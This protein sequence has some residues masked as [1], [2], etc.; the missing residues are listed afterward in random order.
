MSYLFVA[1]IAYFLGAISVI[2]TGIENLGPILGGIRDFLNGL[3]PP[4][5]PF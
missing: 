4:A 5:S 2:Q 3:A 1:V